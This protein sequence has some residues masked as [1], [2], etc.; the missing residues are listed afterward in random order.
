MEYFTSVDLLNAESDLAV[1][2]HMY[3]PVES[4][5][6]R[7]AAL[8]DTGA[9]GIAFLSQSMISRLSLVPKPLSQ[10][11]TLRN[12]QNEHAYDLTTY[13][14]VPLRI[15]QHTESLMAFIIP[16][17][18]Y[19]M[20]LGLPWFERHNPL[21]DWIS[22][23]LTFGES[24]LDKHTRVESTISYY[25]TSRLAISAPC[26]ESLLELPTKPE[27]LSPYIQPSNQLSPK[28]TPSPLNS[29]PV[30]LS[31]SGFA[32][33]CR[34]PGSTQFSLSLREIDTLLEH[35]CHNE[36]QKCRVCLRSI[37]TKIPKDA[38]PKDYVPS[39]YHD[40]LSA[41]DRK[42]ANALP[43]H[44]TQDHAIDIIPGKTPPTSR[45]YSMTQRELFALR[46]YLDKELAK[47]FIRVSRS[48]VS[49]PVLFVK[50]SNGDLRFCIDYRGLNNITIKNRYSLPLI[51]ETLNQLSKAKFYTKLDVISAFNKIR[52][53]E[54][55]E[56]KAAFTTRYGLFEPLVLPFGL[57]NGPSTFQSYINEALHGLLDRFCTAYMDDVL[58][59]SSTL[60]EHRRHVREVLQRLIEFGL[61][62]D[63][64]KCEFDAT[65]VKY[66]GLFI[67]TSGVR[68]DPEKIA[69]IQEWPT[70]KTVKDIQ[71][72]LGFA[73]FY[74]RFIANFSGLASPLTALTRK[75]MKFDWSTSCESAFNQIKKAFND[76]QMLAHFD[77]RR[78]TI[79]ETD[80]SD[81]VTAAILSQYDD[82]D[83][84]RPV[85]F[86]SKKMIPAELNYEIYD[87]ELLAIVNA[88][89]T[90]TAEMGSVESTALVLTDHKNLEYF[91]TTKKLNRRQVRWN[92]LLADFDFKIVFRPGKQNGK[93][94]ALTRIHADIPQD[95]TDDREQHQHQVLLK[96]SQ[97]LRRTTTKTLNSESLIETALTPE[98]W[99]ISCQ[100]DSF[101]QSIR[102]DLQDP[103]AHR[104]DIQ[105]SSC[106]TSQYSFLLNHREYVPETLRITILH[107]LHDT[108]AFGHRGSAALFD[109][110]SQKYWWP[111]CHKDSTKYARGCESCQRNNPSTQRP[112][113]YLHPLPAPQQAF[114]HL[115]LDFVGPLPPC[116]IRGF[117]YRYILQIVDRLTKRVWAIAT[118][119]MTARET[120]SS[121]LNHVFRFSGLPD[122]L[123]SDQGR[124]FIDSTWK[125]ICQALKINHKLST[126]YHPQTDG[127]TER[128]NK[129]LEVYL[130]HFVN[131][132]Q[133]DW[134]CHLPI[135]E[136]SINNHINSSTGISPFFASFGHHPR[137]DFRPESESLDPRS[138][139]TFVN[140]IS[141]IQKQCRES[142]KLAQ[143]YQESYA[144]QKRL[145]A[146]RYKIGDLVYLS[147]K[148]IKTIRPTKKLDQLRAGPWKIIA[149]KTPLVAKLDLPTTLS[150]IDNN[151]HVSLLRP[152]CIGFEEQQQNHPPPVN[153]PDNTESQD[154]Y[155]VEEILDTKSLRG[156]VQYLVRWTGYNDPTWEYKENLDNCE[157]LL[158]EFHNAH[159]ARI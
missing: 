90:W 12:F 134:A 77:P 78:K 84:L 148:N 39:D 105:L 156:R 41:F 24:C 88:F 153:L 106:Q 19:N 56:W 85:A 55:D 29:K 159:G 102:K 124:A 104:T 73:N 83:V 15:G 155:E 109:L 126:S 144:N 6:I 147:L 152:A 112:Y 54:G 92:E 16:A 35:P 116:T 113:G 122:S 79:L 87:K 157:E 53:K 145:P 69:C 150:Q 130:R 37:A 103:D 10:T 125:Q 18:K 43:P 107:Q 142:I 44:R 23:T 47:G 129:S 5:N 63:I 136:F 86:M 93:A 158:E 70:P 139:P 99:K 65:E 120:A 25:N 72:F 138:I 81:F 141:T 143:A 137:L 31:A 75:N 59:Y 42:K 48:P 3:L 2:R 133:N 61:Q 68:M 128:A 151:F 60:R 67:S 117:T 52:I 119:T 38:N 9:S 46:E 27:P 135:A 149:M 36:D 111:D 131:Y 100:N 30:Q 123:V 95:N 4:N 132:Q 57:C 114:R 49:S 82:S 110:L 28:A 32:L 40:L 34:Q 33:A 58:I 64:S 8:G 146:P 108:P 26:F 115:T 1:N 51:Q 14:N 74:R 140:T 121:F 101:C 154:S 98:S 76:N 7:F 80:A 94:D 89:E 127:Q 20:V 97:I 71:G 50:K 96:P 118:E 22:H 17:A 91:T 13:A 66:L 45:P 62:V 21:I 11:I